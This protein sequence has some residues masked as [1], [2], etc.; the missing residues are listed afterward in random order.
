MRLKLFAAAALGA[1]VMTPACALAA[2]V[3]ETETIASQADPYTDTF[4]LP[5]FNSSLGT[6]QSV[7]FVLTDQSTVTVLVNNET[8][9]TKNFSDASASFP[10]TVT[11]PGGLSVADSITNTVASGSLAGHTQASY[12][13]SPVT[14][15]QTETFTTGLSGFESN[16]PLNLSFTA[17]A[18]TGSF[19]GNANGNVLFG[20]SAVTG[21]TFEVIYDYAASAV[22]EPATWAFMM[23]GVGAIGAAMRGRRKAGLALAAV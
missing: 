1:A 21:G 12:P 14:A 5:S 7:E 11:G 23:L 22:P 13:G 19:S 6:L 3:I 2:T 10:L 16:S 17:E 4:I 9:A 18:G 8:G 15:T 20:G